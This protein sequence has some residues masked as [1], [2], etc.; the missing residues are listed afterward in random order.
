MSL[1]QQPAGPIQSDKVLP[2]TTIRSD[3]IVRS[4]VL[5]TFFNVL[6]IFVGQN[7]PTVASFRRHPPAEQI[8]KIHI[9]GVH[10]QKAHTGTLIADNTAQNQP[11]IST[12]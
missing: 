5:F 2:D 11:T 3:R 10:G 12:Q 4:N 8:R 9:S 6:E 1:F 7:F